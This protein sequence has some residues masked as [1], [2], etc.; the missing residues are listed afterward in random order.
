M[1]ELI[2]TSE[3]RASAVRCM[4]SFKDKIEMLM[5]A[6]DILDHC[7]SGRS[8]REE[9]AKARA[10]SLKIWQET[11]CNIAQAAEQG[12]A[13]KGSFRRWLIKEGLHTPK[14]K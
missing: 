7:T 11:S 2:D 12:G 6:G 10:R 8:T 4:E 13:D 5:K 14:T 9:T 3:T 1:V